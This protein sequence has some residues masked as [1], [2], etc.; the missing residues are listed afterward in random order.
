MKIQKIN[1][2]NP[3]VLPTARKEVSSASRPRFPRLRPLANLAGAAA[4]SF[5]LLTTP[6]QGGH[7]LMVNEPRD[8]DNNQA[9]QTFPLAIPR[10]IDQLAALD[11]ELQSR[12]EPPILADMTYALDSRLFSSES[13]TLPPPS[14]LHLSVSS[15]L[16]K[17]LL[18]S[19]QTTHQTKDLDRHE[20]QKLPLDLTSWVEPAILPIPVYSY[21]YTASY[22]SSKSARP[23]RHIYAH[24]LR[25]A[26]RRLRAR[27][28]K[29]FHRYRWKILLRRYREMF[30]YK[31]LGRLS[32]HTKA[33]YGRLLAS[34]T[35]HR[36]QQIRRELKGTA[37]VPRETALPIEKTAK[38]I[39]LST[40]APPFKQ[41]KAA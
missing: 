32:R 15:S 12:I 25:A 26:L 2:L 18:L 7:E 21:S 34:F 39:H 16:S 27:R 22:A 6:L 20:H 24:I 38:I 3:T 11:R 10:S 13:Q 1:P 9:S 30:Y 31:Q 8:R 23:R 5:A 37:R 19:N 36:R 4:L 41:R 33:N 35:Y 40:Y 17:T 29:P 28:K 14:E